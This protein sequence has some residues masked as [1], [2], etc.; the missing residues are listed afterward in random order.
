[1]KRCASRVVVIITPV[2]DG[3]KRFWS[4]LNNS[5]TVSD[6]PL[7]VNGELIVT[8]DFELFH[9]LQNV[10]ARPTECGDSYRSKLS[11]LYQVGKI[12]QS[13][14]PP[15]SQANNKVITTMVIRPLDDPK[16]CAQSVVADLQR[17]RLG[18]GGIG[19][20]LIR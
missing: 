5:K 9:G 20:G 19:D 13:Q 18:H 15:S 7:C 17:L 2:T 12:V 6:K 8:H 1:M 14:F 10:S 3:R 11:H 4:K 16:S